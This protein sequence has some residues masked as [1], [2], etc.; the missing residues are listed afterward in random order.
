MP[1]SNREK[2]FGRAYGAT[3]AIVGFALIY[4]SYTSMVDL[5]DY[6]KFFF[7]FGVV[8]AAMGLPILLLKLR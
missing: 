6:W 2:L 5:G 8:L 4:A 3:L 1:L 7:A